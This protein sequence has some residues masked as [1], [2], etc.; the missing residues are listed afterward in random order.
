MNDTA[1]FFFIYDC[2]NLTILITDILRLHHC[3]RFKLGAG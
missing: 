2:M 3:D 1:H